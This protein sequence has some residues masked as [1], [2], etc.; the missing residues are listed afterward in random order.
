MK[1]PPEQVN[2]LRDG[3][4]IYGWFGGPIVLDAND[5][6]RIGEGRWRMAIAEG[7]TDVPTLDGS[8]LNDKQMTALALLDNKVSRNS[9]WDKSML[10]S[11]L[12]TLAAQA[13]DL[14]KLGFGRLE[15]AA[16]KVPGYEGDGR[17]EGGVKSKIG[18]VR[19]S[20]IIRCDTEAQQAELL[21][22]LDKEG[23]K[24]EA[25]MS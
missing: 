10:A 15:L 18:G 16:L 6:I 5:T 21:E 11:N 7:L 22:R 17:K 23:L 14:S 19:Y 24:V 12:S 20:V 13:V 9:S 25:L 3:F 4:R 8:H 2:E 1:H